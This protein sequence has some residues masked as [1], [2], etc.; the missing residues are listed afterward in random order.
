M[1]TITEIETIFKSGNRQQI[2]M[3]ARGILVHGRSHQDMHELS[4]HAERVNYLL[5]QT[6]PADKEY[7]ALVYILADHLTDLQQGAC[8]CT[9]INKPMYNSPDRLAGILKIL[10]EK[11]NTQEYSTWVHSRCLSCQKEYESVMVE[12][13]FGQKVIWKQCN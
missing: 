9:I 12:S 3:M 1:L 8:A 5:S 11:F 2:E 13:G 6:N 7:L 10:D 4:R